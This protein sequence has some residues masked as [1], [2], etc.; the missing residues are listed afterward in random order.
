MERTSVLILRLLYVSQLTRGADIHLTA[1][2]EH[3]NISSLKPEAS[4][5]LLQQA[6]HDHPSKILETSSN[7]YHVRRKPS[8]YPPK[9]LP[10]N[11]FEVTD[12]DGLS[13]WDQRTIYVEPHLRNICPTPAKVAYWLAEHGELRAKWLPIQAVHTLWNSCASVIL[14][15]SVMHADVWQ[16]W[17]DAGKPENW[18]IM[19][20]VEHTK[21][22]AEYVALLESQ[23]PR[24]MRKTKISESELPAIARPAVLPMAV[25]IAPTAEQHPAKHKRKRRK[26]KKSGKST[27]GDD[28]DADDAEGAYDEPST[29]RRG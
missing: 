28:A 18:K 16:K 24:G 15:G 29:K 12:N 26:P 1:I 14:S 21:R 22:T 9:Y 23:N 2:L 11:S 27:A 25:E 5:V 13:F 3:P 8:T 20:K 10:H 19:T 6:L 17:R 7:G 4:Q